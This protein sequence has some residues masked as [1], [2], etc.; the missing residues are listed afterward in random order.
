MIDYTEDYLLD[1]EIKILQPVN[2]YRASTDAVLLAA[3]ACNIHP[4]D[5]I[6]DI[7]SG[8]GA[9]SLCIA[10][11]FE[12]LQPN[13]TGVEL[14]TELAELANKSAK[15][16]SFDFLKYIN[17]DAFNSGLP[18]CSFDHV[19]TN[20]PYFESS[21]PTSP[22]KG[23]ALA[24]TFGKYNL[25]DW[26]SL[27]IKMVKPQGYFYMINRAEALDEIL[28]ALKGRMG[29]ITIIPLYSKA[30]QAANRVIVRAKKDSKAPLS[31][32][33]GVI[34]HKND[35]AY[36]EEAEQILRKGAAL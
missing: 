10:S 28:T 18:F 23:K 5:A 14:Q 32:A 19:F 17:A 21:M 13:I 11:R 33:K 9:V 31:I 34:I 22:K 4:N 7:G 30:E 29:D 25:A 36:S 12:K 20:P 15:A 35:G 16:N 3:S 24:H 2:G 8:T 27:C 1:K 26:V 6:L